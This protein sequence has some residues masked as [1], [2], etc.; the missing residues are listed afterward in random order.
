MHIA[1]RAMGNKNLKCFMISLVKLN[2]L[3]KTIFVRLVSV[4]RDLFAKIV[5]NECGTKRIDSFFLLSIGF[6]EMLAQ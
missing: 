1:I 2:V 6:W 3:E 4:V 5:Q